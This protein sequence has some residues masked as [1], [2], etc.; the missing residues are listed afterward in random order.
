MVFGNGYETE[1][2]IFVGETR[3]GRAYVYIGI[4]VDMRDTHGR[5]AAYPSQ[6]DF[7]QAFAVQVI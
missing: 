7:L 3:G 5:L 2:P 6:Y 1:L 4:D